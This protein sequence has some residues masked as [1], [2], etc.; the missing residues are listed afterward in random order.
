MPASA[1]LTQVVSATRAKLP[2]WLRLAIA[3][4]SGATLS[5]SFAGLY[6]S[7]YSWVCVGVLLLVVLGASGRVAFACG[8]LHALL[9]VLTS[10]P[11]IAAVL[12]VHGGLSIA[13]GWGVLLLIAAAWGV[14]VGSFTLIVH[15]ISRRS[16]EIACA[17]TP[18]VWVTFEFI[19]AHLPE[20]SFPWNLL[21]YPASANLGLLQITTLTGIYGLSFL[22]ASINALLAWVVASKKKS[23]R[24]RIVIGGGAVAILVIVMLAGPHFV[25]EAK[26]QHFARAVQLNFPEVP[27]YPQDW[28]AKN[29][30]Q[31]DEIAKLSLAPS[32][33]KPD[34]L[35]WPEAPAPFS[36]EDSQF[37]KIASSL[38]IRFGHPFLAGVIEWKL[39]V[40]PLD[41]VPPGRL[42]PYNSAILVDPQGQR[43]FVYDKIHLV[44]FGEYEPFPLIHKVVT[45]VSEEV[46]GFNKGNKYAVGRLPNGNT[47][48]V[49][50]CYEAIYP[51]EVRRFAA[52]GAQLFL[53]ISNDGWFGHS[54]AAEQHLHMVRVRAVENRRWIVRSTNSGYTVSV[55]PYGRIIEPLPPNAR[56]AADLPYDFR[57]DK[58]LYTLF[59][60]WFAWL[61]VIVSVILLMVLLKQGS[62][63][64]RV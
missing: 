30:A 53:N 14:L 33:E 52:N 11:W 49:F 40:D 62:K 46:G 24:Q 5:L 56:A 39:P 4:I 61:C 45:S 16:I 63:E 2:T 29:A 38:A 28:F 18:C 25:P 64:I 8:F 19:R 37:A 34:L 51:G 54:A 50:I 32:A 7:V 9:F 17:A 48:G 60:D 21:G 23:V 3:A 55:D 42:A 6:L 57:T 35:V 12:S 59:G 22:A 10:V 1:G 15:R 47:F 27:E 26:G 58:T 44:P 20:I 13:G 43:V 41:K 36:F 31:L